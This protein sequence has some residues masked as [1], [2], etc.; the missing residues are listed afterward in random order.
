MR[1]ANFKTIYEGDCLAVHYEEG[2]VYDKPVSILSAESEPGSISDLK[3]D[4]NQ[5]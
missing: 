1:Q 5:V 3:S 4:P 2:Q